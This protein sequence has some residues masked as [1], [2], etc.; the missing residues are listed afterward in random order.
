MI[1]RFLHI[2]VVY[3]LSSLPILSLA[4][5]PGYALDLDGVDDYADLGDIHNDLVFPFSVS[6]WI[7]WEGPLDG[8]NDEYA[9]VTA[10]NHPGRNILF[11]QVGV[12]SGFTFFVRANGSINMRLGDGGRVAPASRRDKW[13]PPNVIPLNQWTHVTAVVRGLTDMDLYVN[14][15]DVGGVYDGDG[16]GMDFSNSPFVIGRYTKDDNNGEDYF[17]NGQIEEVRLW[18]YSRTQDD[19]RRDMCHRLEGNEIGLVGY[20]EMNSGAGNALQGSSPNAFDGILQNTDVNTV[21]GL[22]GAPIGDESEQVY[23]GNWNAIDLDLAMGTTSF[24]VNQIQGN[25]QGMHIYGVNPAPNHLNGVAPDEVPFGPYYGTFM[26]GQNN[27]PVDASYQMELEYDPDETGACDPAFSLYQRDDNTDPDWEVVPAAQNT[28]TLSFFPVDQ[29]GEFLLTYIPCDTP[30]VPICVWED[31]EI[32]ME[33]STVC[34]GENNLFELFIPPTNTTDIFLA[35]WEW[36][37]GDGSTSADPA[38][39]HSYDTPGS[40]TVSLTVTDINGCDTLLSRPVEVIAPEAPDLL[41][42]PDTSICA[43]S[44]LSLQAIPLTASSDLTYQWLPSGE[45]GPSID[46]QVDQDQTYT[47]QVDYACGSLTH[48][49]EVSLLPP[50]EAVSDVVPVSCTGL[51][52]GQASVDLSGGQIPYSFV[53]NGLVPSAING[54]QWTANNLAAGTYQI[55]FQDAGGCNTSLELVIE[56]P[57]NPLS[58]AVDSITPDFCEDSTGTA[59]VIATGGSPGSYTYIWSPNLMTE[60]PE[61]D[62]LAAGFYQVRVSDEN[63]CTDSLTLTIPS[64]EA[65][66]FSIDILPTPGQPISFEEASQ[67]GIIFQVQSPDAQRYEWDLGDGSLVE[68]AEFVHFYEEPGTYTVTLRAFTDQASC[69][70]EDSLTLTLDSKEIVFSPSAFSPNGDGINDEFAIFSSGAE[71]LVAHIYDR[72]GKKIIELSDSNPSWDGTLPGGKQ[73]PEGVYVVKFVAEFDSFSQTRTHSLT[74][75]R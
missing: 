61:A 13:S 58:L 50:L 62:E 3:T 29:R 57:A 69:F 42:T 40:Y 4:Q 36:D 34:L 35:S 38:P 56:E 37:F 12:Y 18:S 22:S 52:D 31:L 55:S 47:V 27:V 64:I 59:T 19:I 70:S 8:S 48:T 6:A 24:S 11:I 21:W 51:M 25:L 54:S 46:V 60:G 5:G 20:W 73:A 72:W 49:I 41:F 7:N 2:A 10:D 71:S 68:L 23:A 65:P 30:E 26:A 28:P 17:F 44:T 53:W 32:S 67:D 45:T 9:I 1:S 66:Q 33:D 74:L 75:I 16:N 43:G 14:G 63:N 39:T 15:I